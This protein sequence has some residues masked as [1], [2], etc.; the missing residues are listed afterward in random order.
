MQVG[1]VTYGSDSTP[2][3][4]SQDFPGQFFCVQCPET[5][6]SQI[7]KQE[8]HTCY[9]MASD[10]SKRVRPSQGSRAEILETVRRWATGPTQANASTSENNFL[11][12]AT[13]WPT[14]VRIGQEPVPFSCVVLRTE[15]GVLDAYH[16]QCFCPHHASSPRVVRSP[17]R[18]RP[19][20]PRQ[21]CG[22]RNDAPL[23]LWKYLSVQLTRSGLIHNNQARHYQLLMYSGSRGTFRSRDLVLGNSPPRPTVKADESQHSHVSCHQHFRYTRE[24]PEAIKS[25]CTTVGHSSQV[26]SSHLFRTGTQYRIWIN[27]FSVSGTFCK[28]NGWRSF[29]IHI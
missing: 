16:V 12:P 4:P 18:T 11:F 20:S 24:I 13:R 17:L 25:P 19:I 2:F 14:E 28:R 5:N 23:R 3:F 6:L 21:P 10:N 27:C 1:D 15:Y 22:G 7:T 29:V 8:N 9:S 26:I